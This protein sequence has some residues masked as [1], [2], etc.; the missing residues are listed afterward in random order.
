M[1]ALE[2]GALLF[3]LRHQALK[4]RLC[5]ASG[6]CAIQNLDYARSLFWPFVEQR[7]LVV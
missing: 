6:F 1:P 5:L 7:V 2:Q 4:S 3:K